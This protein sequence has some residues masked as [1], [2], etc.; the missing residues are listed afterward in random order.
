MAPVTSSSTKR[1][2]GRPRAFDL[3]EVSEQ[4]LVVFWANGYEATSMDQLVA[5]TGLSASS[6][7]AAFVN[8]RGL[9][10]AAV[11]R[12]DAHAGE[13][14]DA[15]HDGSRGLRDVARFVEWVREGL[16]SDSRPASCL[17]V[18]TMV[19]MAS[20]DE[21]IAEATARYRTRV[22]ESLRAAMAR[23]EAQG[24][25]P[26]R[27]ARQRADVVNAALFG[28]LAT[29]RAGSVDDADRMLA[30][31]LGELRRWAQPDG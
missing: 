6:I 30:S 4:A 28:A 22:R 12:Y 11:A 3:D 9:F 21:V 15:L 25:L 20:R 26:R 13:A 5:A 29:A 18:N 23:A 7:Y 2:R 1:P 10:E 19:E 24:E 31:L 8:K 16:R 27:S 17:I 14:L